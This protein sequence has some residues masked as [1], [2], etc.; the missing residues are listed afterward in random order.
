MAENPQEPSFWRGEIDRSRRVAEPY[1]TKWQENLNYY[2]GQ[3]L[4]SAPSADYVNVNVDFYQVEQK[5][6]QLFFDTPELQL[7]PGVGFDAMTP[8]ILAHRAVLNALVGMDRMDVLTTTLKAIKDCT[9]TAGFGPTVIGYQ[10]TLQ[11]IAAP[12][13]P[14]GADGMPAP[15]QP[16]IQV[17]I[18]EQWFWERVPSKKFRIPADFHDSDYDKA[19]WLAEDFRIPLNLAKQTLNLPPDFTGTTNKDDKVFEDANKS[20]EATSVAYIDGT[21]IWYQAALFDEDVIHPLIFR[22]HVLID[23]VEGFVDRPEPMW[24]SPYQTIGPNG[25][26]TPDSMIGNPIHVLTLRDVP[27]SAYVPSDCQMTRSLVKELCLFRTQM[28]QERDANK[29]K[30]GYNSET[31]TP[32]IVSK[33]VEA[34]TGSLIPLPAA[35]FAG[36]LD[37]HFKLLAQGSSPRQTYQA[38]DYIE[39]DIQKTL[40]IGNNASGVTEDT[41]RTATEINQVEHSL[42]VAMDAER[43]RVLRWYL[44]GIDKVSA[45]A[46]RYLTDPQRVAD[47]I[48][49]EQAQAW[50]TWVGDLKK[51]GDARPIFTAKPDSQIKLDAAAERKSA[52]ALYQMVRKDPLVN[53]GELLNALF[54]KYGLDPHKLVSQ[55]PPEHKPEP[56]VGFSFK[57][58]DLNP[59]MPQQPIVMSILAQV[60]IQVDPQAVQLANDAGMNQHMMNLVQPTSTAFPAHG[61]PQEHGGAAPQV[62]PLSKHQADITGQRAG[63]KAG[64]Q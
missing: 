21:L 43:K 50:L 18:H 26:L 33:L 47:L 63:P 49:P 1:H 31:F 5:G 7:T 42:Q 19:P 57:G 45:L 41:T 27:D 56:S 59:L 35:A 37:S 54:V 60:G 46:I 4:D 30:F 40:R 25:R 52:I 12:E 13:Q 24:K 62:S 3:P 34:M 23:G 10:P 32:D 36:G 48:G 16:P 15:V 61:R 53:G 55:A 28:V 9:C 44:K 58:D 20:D 51:M 8:G 11:T 2:T 29:V 6:A 64:V 14:P 39:R 17:P 22:R 38:N